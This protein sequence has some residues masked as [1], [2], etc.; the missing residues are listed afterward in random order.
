[1]VSVA[2]VFGTQAELTKTIGLVASVPADI[3]L[4]VCWTGQH[5]DLVPD[6]ATDLGQP[7]MIKDSLVELSD[8]QLRAWLDRAAPNLV[9]V[10]GD[11]RS[12]L[13]GARAASS[14]GIRVLHLEAGLRLSA[15]LE[16]E[17]AHRREITALADFHV[18]SDDRST[19][20]LRREGVPLA[21]IRTGVPLASIYLGYLSTVAR[22]RL[23]EGSSGAIVVTIH[24][25]S[26][27]D[28]QP[29]LSSVLKELGGRLEGEKIVLIRRPD[30]RWRPLYDELAEVPNIDLVDELLPSAFNDLIRR[31]KAVLTDSAGVHQECEIL[32]IPH[33]VLRPESELPG[34]ARHVPILDAGFIYEM[35]VLAMKEGRCAQSSAP[36]QWRSDADRFWEWVAEWAA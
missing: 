6:A 24:R 14:L 30:A 15:V 21:K 27:I 29:I 23:A 1:M 16:P 2:L 33:V 36:S 12:A 31:A 26:A 25:A 28:R 9:V 32:G 17:E 18:S 22:S 3:D 5:P 35:I 19:S 10:Q 34:R 4:G 20:N 13:L 7:V 8:S 11:T